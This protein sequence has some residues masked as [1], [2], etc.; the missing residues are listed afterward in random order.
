MTVHRAQ[1]SEYPAVVLAYDH[2]AHRPMLDRR[3]L[4]TGITRAR[5]HL[6]LVGTESALH[7]TRE[8]STVSVRYTT[9]AHHLSHLI[10][11]LTR[12]T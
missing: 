9:L 3:L 1:G 5:E 11:H 7:E 10:P 4:Y 6:S 12:S 2:R 8:R